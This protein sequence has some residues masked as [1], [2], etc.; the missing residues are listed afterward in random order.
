MKNTNGSLRRL[1]FP[2]WEISALEKRVLGD[3]FNATKCRDH[4]HA[5]VVEF[6]NTSR[7]V[8]VKSTTKDCCKSTYLTPGI[9][10][11]RHFTYCL[12]SWYCFQSVPI[13]SDSP[14]SI[15]SETIVMLVYIL[16]QAQ[17]IC[18]RVMIFLEQRVDSRNT[19]IPA[20]FEVFQGQTTVLRIGF[21]SL[22]GVLR[23]NTSR[24][25]E[26]HLPRLQVSV[27]IRNE[28]VLLMR[29]PSSEVGTCNL[30][31]QRLEEMSRHLP[32]TSVCFDHLRS[33]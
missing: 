23:P 1:T 10:F 25:E 30:L 5:I 14:P 22:H 28:L 32:V 7:H 31:A 3:T 2:S 6:A 26:F 27:Q 4:I 21:L 20:V 8:A 17:R 16:L 13:C 33:L 18:S 11:K 24:V 12:G 19:T 9:I 15:I 29:H